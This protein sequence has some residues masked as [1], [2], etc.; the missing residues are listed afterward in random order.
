MTT[1]D[2][3]RT[4]TA[5]VTDEQGPFS[6]MNLWTSAWQAVRNHTVVTAVLVVVSVAALGFSVYIG[7]EVVVTIGLLGIVGVGAILLWWL[8]ARRP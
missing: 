2:L 1:G 3:L 5:L 8:W 4:H 6:A 7:L